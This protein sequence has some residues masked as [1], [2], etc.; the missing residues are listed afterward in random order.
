MVT[1]KTDPAATGRSASFVPAL[2]PHDPQIADLWTRVRL[3]YLR[4]Y[5]L[6]NALRKRHQIKRLSW[7]ADHISAQMPLAFATIRN[8]IDRLEFWLEHHRAMG[9]GHFLIVDNASTDGSTEYLAKQSDVS[10]WTTSE[11]YKKARFGIDWL[12]CLQFRYGRGRWCLT[13]DADELFVYP[14]HDKR[15]I[16][17][18]TN[19]LE[20]IGRRSFGALMIDLYPDGPVGDGRY[21]SG[22]DPTHVLPWFD[23]AGYVVQ[24]KTDLLNLWVRGG[25]RARLFYKDDIDRA[26]TLSKVP[27]V[28]WSM[29]YAYVSSTHS[30]LPRRL[31]RVYKEDGSLGVSGALLHTKFLPGIRERSAEEKARHEHFANGPSHEGYYDWLI[32]APNMLHNGSVKYDGWQ[33]L[34]SL[35]L[36]SRGDWM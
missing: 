19:H 33:Q 35:G 27:L 6:W 4:R 3:H 8:E 22:D 23:P 20:S 1:T 31:N 12:T 24:R 17:D 30:I 10:V 32:S 36:M 9:I 16:G 11:S 25:P 28:K 7:R 15:V 14:Y 18:L 29:P 21:T 34:E 2:P 5:L 13:L 26:P